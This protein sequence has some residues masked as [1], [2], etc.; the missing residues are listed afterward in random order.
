MLSWLVYAW[1][2]QNPA[3]IKLKY[4]KVDF[5]NL[6]QRWLLFILLDIF[7]ITMCYSE[8]LQSIYR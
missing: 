6:L 7:A 1:K 8:V 5:D 4:C 3:L 2:T